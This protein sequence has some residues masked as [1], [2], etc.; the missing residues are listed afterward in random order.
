MQE[1]LLD[2]A[3][4]AAIISDTPELAGDGHSI[5]QIADRF[6]RQYL[7]AWARAGA[8][9][10]R[11]RVWQAFW[12]YLTSAPTPRKAFQLSAESAD[13]LIGKIRERVEGQE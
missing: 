7:S 13:A 4:W 8:H 9:E 2:A 11:E 12:S 10:M 3:R 6:T 1:G 5:E